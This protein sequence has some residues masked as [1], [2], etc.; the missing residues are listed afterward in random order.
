MDG[1]QLHMVPQGS[2]FR[3][4]PECDIICVFFSFRFI[5]AI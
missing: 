2:G 5:T 1:S 3:E 4:T